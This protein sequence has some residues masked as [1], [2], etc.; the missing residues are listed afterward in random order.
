M[1]SFGIGPRP[2]ANR[3]HMEWRALAVLQSLLDMAARGTM[4]YSGAK[5]QAAAE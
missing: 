1:R 5:R 2:G 3:R 4:Y